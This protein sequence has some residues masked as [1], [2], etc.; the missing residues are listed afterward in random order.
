V[1]DLIASTLFL[2][3]ILVPTKL[4]YAPDQA[5]TIDV[6]PDAPVRLV[7]VDFLGRAVDTQADTSVDAARQVNVRELFPAMQSG[8]Y[9]LY[10]VPKDKQLPDFVGTPLVVQVQAD[11]R[12]GAQP[13]PLVARVEPLRYMTMKTSDGEMTMAFY[14]DVAPN[15][16]DN[17]LKLGE[18]GYFDGQVFHRIVKDF[19]IQGGDPL[20]RDPQRAGTGGPGYMIDAEFNDR[21]HR[22]GVF[23]MARQGDPLER[24]G[25]MPR[26]DAANSAS[27]QFFICL[28][29][30][31]TKQ[32]DNKYTVFGKVVEGMDVVDKIA[33]RE[34]GPGDR[35]TNPP[36]M[37]DVTVHVVTPGNN[38]YLKLFA[39]D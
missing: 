6:R 36:E 23:S 7:L 13:G 4:W 15:T 12:P 39:V 3:S 30:D 24:Q 26:S 21:Q 18:Q 28:N 8:T 33:A 27:S 35:P 20:G 10:A 2:F 37:T 16:V 9:V 11:K 38:P 34:T 14:Y 17:F 19:V 22:K 31:R 25:M 32:L 5:I 29:Y 1:S